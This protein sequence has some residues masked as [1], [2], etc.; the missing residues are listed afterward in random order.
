MRSSAIRR[1]ASRAPPHM[2]RCHK[3]VI[4]TQITFTCNLCGFADNTVRLGD[5][6]RETAPCA[7][8]GANVRLRA[9]IH[10]M[11]LHL[12]RR[13]LPVAQWPTD[14]S[15]VGYGVSD[16]PR[17][18]DFLLPK[19]DYRNT[20]FDED[21]R[22]D[23]LFL[24]VTAPPAHLAGTA[25]FICCSEVLEHVAPPVEL[26]FDGL[27]SILKPGGALIFSVPYW[28]NETIEHFPDLYHWNIVESD[29]GPVLV[30]TTRAGEVQTF[31]DLRF[32]GGGA[33]VLE[34][35]VFGYPDL[36]RHLERAGFERAETLH[37]EHLPYGIRFPEQWSLPIIARKPHA[38]R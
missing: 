16:W 29:S 27:F 4:M 5:L 25:D 12:W 21:L 26:A 31:K 30:N 20:Q 22:G 13:S 6:A 35:R 34:M 18:S 1:A 37:V 38:G 10:L 11:S 33:R 28:L 14:R 3:R 2:S 23:R 36:M 32:H 15:I 8:C 9:L 24:D 7:Q 17:F 19:L